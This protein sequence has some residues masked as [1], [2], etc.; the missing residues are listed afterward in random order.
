M[1]D[2]GANGLNHVEALDS[3]SANYFGDPRNYKSVTEENGCWFL[4]SLSSGLYF[5]STVFLVVN[6]RG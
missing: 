2:E 1:E 5:S 3:S 4:R 6:W